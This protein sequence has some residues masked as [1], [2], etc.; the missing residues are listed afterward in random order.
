MVGNP[1]EWLARLRESVEKISKTILSIL[2]RMRSSAETEIL[3]VR[4]RIEEAGKAIVPASE[5]A[6]ATVSSVA[7]RGWGR[8][9]P[10]MTGMVV[11]ALKKTKE[12]SVATM[13]GIRNRV[14][15]LYAIRIADFLQ[16]L[17]GFFR[18]FSARALSVSE[19]F[20]E[21]APES[22]DSFLKKA[23]ALLRPVFAG[24]RSLFVRMTSYVGSV[25][26]RMTV[27]ERMLVLFAVGAALGFGIKTIAS[28]FLTIGYQ[29]YTLKSA[30]EPYDLNEV[31]RR[32]MERERAALMMS[33]ES[34]VSGEEEIPE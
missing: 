3:S 28:G 13:L 26:G 9:E 22:T 34:V 12:S 32:L 24:I 20:L 15:T 33:G 2:K 25:F 11:P 23:G 29:D 10:F 19:A 17:P 5:R 21:R 8:V 4:K 1:E 18:S 16:R 6:W 27:R 31:E 30:R 7:L 14:G